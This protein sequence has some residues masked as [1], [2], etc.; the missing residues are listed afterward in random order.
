MGLSFRQ[1]HQLRFCGKAWLSNQPC[2]AD[3][4]V[5]VRTFV[6]LYQNAQAL[7]EVSGECC[8]ITTPE[9]STSL[10]NPQMVQLPEI[11]E[12]PG[13]TTVSCRLGDKGATRTLPT[14]T[15]YAPRQ[16]CVHRVRA[17][18][19]DRFAGLGRRYGRI[20]FGGGPVR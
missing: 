13:G 2:C 20:G 11:K 1:R 14:G 12:K 6:E 16:R 18:G 7:H 8:T 17:G 19:S 15:N 9:P 5:T 4:P 10:V 3:Q